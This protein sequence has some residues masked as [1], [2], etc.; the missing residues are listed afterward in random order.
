M[1]LSINVYITRVTVYDSVPM[2]LSIP[3]HTIAGNRGRPDADP[4]SDGVVPAWSSSLGSA[5]SHL[6]VPSGHEAHA[7]PLAIVEL[8]RIA[9][10]HL[11]ELPRK[12]RG[13]GEQ[14]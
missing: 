7:H 11:S 4:V 13:G 10:L 12:A 1:I 14:E 5:V 3:V 8:R 2:D 6:D 9:R